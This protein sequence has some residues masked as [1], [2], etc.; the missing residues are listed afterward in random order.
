[1]VD[2]VLAE[3]PNNPAKASHAVGELT[4]WVGREDWHEILPAYHAACASRVIWSSAYTF[5]PD[6][7]VEEAERGLYQ[8]L[9]KAE[10]ADVNRVRWMIF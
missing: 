7:A 1:M 10:P 3:Q 9:L 4:D 2:A 6:L 5:N 8:A